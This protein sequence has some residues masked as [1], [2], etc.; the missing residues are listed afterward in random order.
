MQNQRAEQA[1]ELAVPERIEDI[2]AAGKYNKQT[3]NFKCRQEGQ[4]KE[5]S[6]EGDLSRHM[7]HVN[8]PHFVKSVGSAV[9]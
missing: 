1:T 5:N 4:K 6:N 9:C 7:V 2:K 8:A 3:K